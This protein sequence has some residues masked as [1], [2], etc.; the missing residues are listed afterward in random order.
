MVDKEEKLPVD[1]LDPTSPLRSLVHF[2]R[3][4][5]TVHEDEEEGEG[6]EDDKDDDDDVEEVEVEEEE[7]DDDEEDDDDVYRLIEL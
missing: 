1:Y 6:D 5:T 2:T 4:V 3:I 7:E